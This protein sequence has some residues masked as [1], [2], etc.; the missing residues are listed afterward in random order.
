MP[1][2]LGRYDVRAKIGEGGMATVYVGRERDGE[3]RAVALKVIKDEFSINREFVNMFIDEAR[4]V[5]RLSHPNVVKLHE[6]GNEGGRLFIVMELLSGH[7]LWE[8][9]EASRARKLPLGYD[10]VAWIGA[11]IADGLHHA[12][13]LTDDKGERQRIVHRDV[14]ATNV[15]VSYDGSVKIIDFGLAKAINR[16]SKTAA[17]VVKGKLAYLS[18]EQASGQEVDQ[19]ADV[20]AL[21]TTLWELSTDRRLFRQND[22]I[23]TLKKIHAA[24]IPDP[25]TLLPD[26]PQ[27]LWKILQRALARDR[28]Q[29]YATAADMAK[30]LDAFVGKRVGAADVSSLMDQLF[31]AERQRQEAWLAEV[32]GTKAGVPHGTLKPPTNH[33]AVIPVVVPPSRLPSEALIAKAIQPRSPS[34]EAPATHIRHSVPVSLA[35]QD[36]LK[37]RPR[38]A[39]ILLLVIVAIVAV[40]IVLAVISRS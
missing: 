26:F 38:S 22:D 28:T 21:G 31:A 2:V 5:A 35:S 32:S 34:V 8:L 18:P 23:E 13:E 3:R 40:M 14:N 7:S 20:F 29:R 9:W 39:K 6:L 16:V 11:R 19:R 37:S 30:D 27:D 1:S 33:A 25:T 17:G 36:K 12:H 15:F 24:V 10:R 4:I